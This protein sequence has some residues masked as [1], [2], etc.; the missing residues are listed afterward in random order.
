MEL[1]PDKLLALD[2]LQKSKLSASMP[3]RRIARDMAVHAEL[4]SRATL[5]LNKSGILLSFGEDQ[6][7][8][9]SSG[10]TLTFDIV[11]SGVDDVAAVELMKTW[12][13]ALF[14]EAGLLGETTVQL[15]WPADGE[16]DL[17][18]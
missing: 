12:R 3:V 10:A 4:F 17:G 7:T 15:N 14:V 11:T 9:P 16:V 5:G 13:P 18:E 1:T 8:P 6:T 2:K